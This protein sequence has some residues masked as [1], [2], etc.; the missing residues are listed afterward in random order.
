[1]TTITAL[2]V[3]T[4]AL[5]APVQEAQQ[6]MF[7]VK[8]KEIVLGDGSRIEDGVLLI[9]G[10]KIRKLG[11]GVELDA[12]YP[13][14][15]HE[16]VLTA[17][18][19]VCQSQSGADGEDYDE[20]RSLLPEARM[21]YAFDRDHS[22]FEKALRCGVTTLVLTPSEENLAGGLTAVVKS[23]GDDVVRED[24][25]LALSFTRGALTGGPRGFS[26]F[27]GAAESLSSRSGGPENTDSSERG[28]RFPTSYSGAVHALE[29][30][31]DQ[32]SGPFLAASNGELPVLMEAWD[33]NEIA[34][35]LRFARERGLR[36]AIVGATLA[37]DFSQQLAA[38]GLGVVLGPFHV[39]QTRPS[40][41][42]V[43]RLTEA[44]VTM[45]FALDAP[46]YDPNQL[47]LSIG[48]AL[49]VGADK[50]QVWKALTS[51]AARIA[52]VEDRV[53]TLERGKDADFVLWSGDP[54]DL[55]SRVQAVYVGG[56]LAYRGDQ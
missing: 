24:A 32:P 36:G 13:V 18:M 47:R 3:S 7:Q 49:S 6:G 16:G 10:G 9:E 33:R 25:H 37:G 31:F 15:E 42:S 52:G 35:A 2:F 11:R 46:R 8:A 29:Q 39:G 48:L 56:R 26:L 19:V 45:A 12:A 55:K 44:G 40:L 34:R 17:G 14:I 28:T 30:R 22:D 43:A 50:S 38:S 54:L 21:V 1:M 51:D 41:E 53:G 5:A 4:L 20:S 23:T 27:F